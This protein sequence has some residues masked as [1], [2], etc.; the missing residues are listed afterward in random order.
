[1]ILRIDGKYFN[2]AQITVMVQAE[3]NVKVFQSDTVEAYIL[4]ENWKIDDLAAEIN[5][6]IEKFHGVI[7]E[8]ALSKF[9][10]YKPGFNG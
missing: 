7:F 8:Y 6:Q 5:I 9:L 4:F 2:P 1:M 3:N 10:N